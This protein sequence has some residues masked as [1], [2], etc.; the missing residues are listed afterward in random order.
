MTN[1]IKLTITSALKAELHKL[2]FPGDDKE[3][4]AFLLCGNAQYDH[5]TKLVVHDIIPL[6]PED[7][8]ER[9]HD[10]VTWS[11]NHLPEILEVA[12]KKGMTIIKIH[13]HPNGYEFFSE[14]DNQAD[15]E[16]FPSIYSWLEANQLHGS[17]IMLPDGIIKARIV[18][19]DLSFLPI[20]NIQEIGANLKY[21]I[22]NVH[23]VKNEFNLR[24]HQAF[25][26]GTTTI[27]GNL[28]IAVVGCSG[29]GSIVVEQLARLGVGNLILIDPDK[30][31]KKNLNRIL[32]STLHDAKMSEFKVHVLERSIHSFGIGNKVRAIPQNLYDE[33]SIINELSTCDVLFGCVD[34][35]DGRHML[36]LIS[37][38]YS[39]PYFDL[40]VKLIADG[41]G[42]INQICGTVH[43]IMP[44]GS[45]LYTRGVYSMEDLRAANMYRTNPKE[46]H[47]QRKSGYIS[48]VNVD[49]PAV[50][51]VNMLTASLAVNEFLAR[52]H[53]FRYDPNS[54]Y[55]IFRFSLSDGYFQ[56]DVGGKSDEYLSK[57]VGRGDMIPML[58]IL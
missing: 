30:V 40:G 18:T 16:L 51:S 25:G 24:T 11:T 36:N 29:T 45:S 12:S 41:K 2:L 15:Y 34:S 33:E 32:N 5:V 20:E 14:T 55:D 13:S 38:F 19:E 50:I 37:T 9:F 58:N 43:Y 1:K 54:N 47:E 6:E 27:L 46:F 48:N 49:S 3:S 57:F 10:S 42:G 21:S 35:V 7:Y 56:N 8:S 26:E 39:V 31:E 4:V 17:A 28:K 22:N 44:G 52:I 23:K 53:P